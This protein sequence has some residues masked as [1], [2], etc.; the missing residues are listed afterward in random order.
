MLHLL[1]GAVLLPALLL[2]TRSDLRRRTI[3]NALTATTAG[4]LL[5][6]RA[7]TAPGTVPPALAWA[8]AAAV[9]LGALALA[10]PDGMG[11]GDAKLAGVLG[12]ALG[13]GAVLA[14][15]AGFLAATGAGAVVAARQGIATAR[16][17]TLPLA[18]FLAAGGALAWAV[19]WP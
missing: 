13:P 11:M 8:A 1:T 3:P 19:G 10:A 4:A 17:A 18:P 9:P 7:A 6:A 2:A 15:L 14:L 16:Q 5:V 12:L